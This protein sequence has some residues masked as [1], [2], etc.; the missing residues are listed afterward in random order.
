[1]FGFKCFAL[2]F[3]VLFSLSA[4]ANCLKTAQGRA[5]INMCINK[6]LQEDTKILERLL[7]SVVDSIEDEEKPI[8]LGADKLWNEFAEADCGLRTKNSGNMEGLWFRLCTHRRNQH[9]IYQLRSH[10]CE[11][12]RVGCTKADKQEYGQLKFSQPW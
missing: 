1:M 4:N 9:R 7:V 5:P 12:A 2:V 10:L 11:P 8:F 6:L 3:G